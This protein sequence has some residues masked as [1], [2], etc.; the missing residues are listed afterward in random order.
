MRSLVC[1]IVL[2]FFC[3]SAFALMSLKEAQEVRNW[4]GGKK[5]F[6]IKP[7]EKPRIEEARKVLKMHGGNDKSFMGINNQCCLRSPMGPGPINYYHCTYRGGKYC[8]MSGAACDGFSED[9]Y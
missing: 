8:G 2:Q 1:V 3:S 7:N 6:E 4:A 5:I 9:C